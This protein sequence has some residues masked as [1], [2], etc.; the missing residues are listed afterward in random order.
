MT[1]IR[2]VLSGDTR[3]AWLARPQ[4]Q[5]KR[6]SDHDEACDEDAHCAGLLQ[7]SVTSS[8]NSQEGPARS[9]RTLYMMIRPLTAHRRG[10][11]SG[12]PPQGTAGLYCLLKA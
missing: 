4:T 6:R 5:G 10:L 12:P 9:F 7:F 2:K 11:C 8:I 1:F 3:H